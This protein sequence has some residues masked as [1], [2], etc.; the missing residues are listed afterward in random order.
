VAEWGV[1]ATVRAPVEQVLA[2]AAYHLSLG[3]AEVT[4]CLDEPDDPALPLL[5]GVPGVTAIRCDAEWWAGFGQDRPAK[6]QVRQLRN[7][8]RILRQTALPWVAHLDVDE[9]LLPAAPVADVLGRLPADQPMLRLPPFEALHDPGLPDDIHAATRFRGAM[10]GRQYRDLRRAVFGD[11]AP[12]LPRGM[13]SHSEGKCFFRSGVPGFQARLHAGFLHGQ[14][15]DRAP[16]DPDLDL[17][18]FHAQDREAWLAALPFRLT[19]GAYQFNTGLCDYLSGSTAE[20]IAAFY[21]A[22]QCPGP[23]AVQ[24]LKAAGLLREARLGLRDR[25]AAL[26]PPK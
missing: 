1:C 16:D 9:F 23:D 13:L 24:A 17:L 10:Q 5:A 26:I 11:H 8:N 4:L 21:D 25:V 3:A 20:E 14:R 6:H 19:Q 15:L 12:L 2:F 7:I 18:H 22:V